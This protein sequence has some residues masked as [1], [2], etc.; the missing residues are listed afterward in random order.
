MWA[1]H[2]SRRKDEPYLEFRVG[3]RDVFQ[4]YLVP[5]GTCFEIGFLPGHMLTYLSKHF[6]YSASGIDATPFDDSEVRARMT[7]NGAKVGK[8]FRSD[9]LTFQPEE[10]YD[11]VCS[12]GFIEHFADTEDIL[13]RHLALLK[14]GGTLVVSCP[15]FRGANYALHLRL[16]RANLLN[17]NLSSMDLGTWERILTANHM[18]ILFQDYYGTFGFWHDR[19]ANAPLTTQAMAYALS[20]IAFVADLLIRYP[21]PRTSPSMI[22]VSR[23]EARSGDAASRS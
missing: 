21:N 20:R 23:R 10:K 4:N 18:R 1:R 12:F 19:D 15:N 7:S 11:V 13:L 9:F 14:P 6:G 3:Y 8:L 17:H 16:D 22:S 2:Y 5:G